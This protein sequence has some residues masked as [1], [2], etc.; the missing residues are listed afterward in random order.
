MNARRVFLAALVVAL[1]AALS[2]CSRV[3]GVS[4]VLP[5]KADDRVQEPTSA[6]VS[7][8]VNGDLPADTPDDI[9]LW[10]GATVKSAATTDGAFDLLLVTA[11]S[12]EDIVN[13]LGLGF[14]RAGWSVA[15][16]VE[17]DAATVLEVSN[18]TLEGMVTVSVAE[19]GNSIEYLLTPIGK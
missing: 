10:P 14:E 7:A 8:S 5:A 4:D 16:S 11:D 1:A 6:A 2:G 9:P 3:S 19:E 18:D 17:S 12:I 15:S 13:G